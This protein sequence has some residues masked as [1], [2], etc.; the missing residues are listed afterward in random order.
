MKDEGDG[1]QFLSFILHSA[2][3]IPIFVAKY[4]KRTASDRTEES[5]DQ[6][7]S[8]TVIWRMFGGA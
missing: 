1:M 8:R 4:R 2:S 6:A 3:L 7:E 5:Y